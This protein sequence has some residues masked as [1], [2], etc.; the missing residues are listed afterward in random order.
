MWSRFAGLWT[1]SL[2]FRIAAAVVIVGVIR[3][4]A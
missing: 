1:D 2:A 3:M 4:F